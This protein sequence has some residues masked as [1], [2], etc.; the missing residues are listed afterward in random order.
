MQLSEERLQREM[1]ELTQDFVTLLRA[2]YPRLLNA[3]EALSEDEMIELMIE[4]CDV[5]DLY[6]DLTGEVARL[7]QEHRR[8]TGS[9]EERDWPEN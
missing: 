8:S 4:L 6:K 9:L 7:Y 5:F 2:K 3:F 1:L